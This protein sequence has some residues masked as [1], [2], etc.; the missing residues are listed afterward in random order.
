VDEGVAAHREG[1]LQIAGR[2]F[3]ALKF[4][5]GEVDKGQADNV[6]DGVLKN[7]REKI[8]SLAS[9]TATSWRFPE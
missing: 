9:R 5:G 7:R 6:G 3:G 4:A 2:K 8:I 1:L